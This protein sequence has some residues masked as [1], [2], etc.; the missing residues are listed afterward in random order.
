[1]AGK[2]R[3]GALFA[4]FAGEGAGTFDVG[5]EYA[6]YMMAKSQGMLA[7]S[8]FREHL[9]RVFRKSGNRFCDQNTRKTKN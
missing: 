6:V 4:Q 9:T 5:G 1:M 3:T 2:Q 7:K 8:A